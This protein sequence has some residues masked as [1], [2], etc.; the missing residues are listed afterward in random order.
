LNSFM[1]I[2]N[3]L[4]SRSQPKSLQGQQRPGTRLRILI[5]D[6]HAVIR[7]GFTSICRDAG[8]AIVG[9]ARSGEELLSTLERLPVDVLLLDLRMPSTRVIDTLVEIRNLPSPPQ[10]I[11][12]SSFEPDERVCDAVEAGA[13]GFLL[14]DSSRTNIVEAICAVGSGCCC[15]PPWITSRISERKGRPGLSPREL[16]VLE[17][18]SKGL[19]NKEIAQAI[20]VSH[21]TVRNHVR[22]IID[23]LDV[24]DRTE[25]ATLAIKQGIL[26][27]Y[28]VC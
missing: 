22:R 21:F 1:G 26:S 11:I 5:A 18:V 12:L 9:L 8:F 20:Q 7:E 3:A 24:G 28:G 14:K 27:P 4:P 10:V 23:K 2:G 15:L 6:D 16:E 19:T 17:M 13:T 25:A